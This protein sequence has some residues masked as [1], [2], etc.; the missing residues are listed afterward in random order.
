MVVQP[1]GMVTFLFTDIESSPRSWEEH[2]KLMWSASARH[3]EILRS[4]IPVQRRVV[5]APGGDGFA[6]A[7]SV[8]TQPGSSMLESAVEWPKSPASLAP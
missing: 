2:P 6:A 1:S 4:A 7:P 5:L 8:Q 3:D